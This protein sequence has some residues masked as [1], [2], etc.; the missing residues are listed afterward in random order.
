MGFKKDVL[1][2]RARQGGYHLHPPADSGKIRYDATMQNIS[3]SIIS[4][5]H[6]KQRILS[7][8][9]VTIK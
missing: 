1:S 7:C 9:S 3:F 6:I 2:V 5:F 4:A 8:H